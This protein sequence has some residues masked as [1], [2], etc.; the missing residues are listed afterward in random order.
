MDFN[1]F[2]DKKYG[3]T[4]AKMPKR[5][6]LD[7]CLSYIPPA[8]R[9]SLFI[10]KE[11]TLWNKASYA[12]YGVIL[13]EGIEGTYEPSEII[14]AEKLGPGKTKQIKKNVSYSEMTEGE[15]QGYLSFLSD[16]VQ[17]D[18]GYLR[19]LIYALERNVFLNRNIVSTVRTLTILSNPKKFPA[20][21]YEC[22]QLMAVAAL[23][24]KDPKVLK[25]LPL[26][27]IHPELMFL[28]KI[29]CQQAFSAADLI[30]LANS[31]GYE[32][33]EHQMR[34]LE[35][36]E[37]NLEKAITETY[38]SSTIQFKLDKSL[39]TDEAIVISLL[40][41][42]LPITEFKFINL[43][44]DPKFKSAILP[45]FNQAAL[46][47]CAAENK[48]RRNQL[49]RMLEG[50]PKNIDI[51]ND[52]LSV[53]QRLDKIRGVYKIDVVSEE[54]LGIDCCI[55]E[56]YEQAEKHLLRAVRKRS[57]SVKPYQCLAHMYQKQNRYVDAL[58]IL[59]LG[60]T[61]LPKHSILANQL[62]YVHR[63]IRAEKHQNNKLEKKRPASAQK[64]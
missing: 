27:K 24:S 20:Y 51:P 55:R 10:S 44:S 16:I 42:S 62:K 34:N 35:S 2:I 52:G 57:S 13:S 36:F 50:R 32:L 9:N 25:L 48:R 26:Y 11:P 6:K 40:N 15:R 8:I 31:A 49:M 4:G 18:A 19:Y 14:V 61:R 58:D 33:E 63:L 12:K 54:A 28:L 5:S 21:S 47:P 17:E 46:Q 59:N 29:T 43:L 39:N 3:V 41:P 7:I 45:L 38:G 30:Y 64:K 60:L 56:R 22:S 23:K 37:E 53:Q 1:S